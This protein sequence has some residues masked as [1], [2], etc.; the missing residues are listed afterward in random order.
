MMSTSAYAIPLQVPSK[1]RTCKNLRQHSFCDLPS[2][3]LAELER[4][5]KF[6]DY[7]P[8]ERIFREGEPVDELMIVCEGAVTLTFSASGGN[9]MMLGLSECGEMLGLSSHL[10]GHPHE[11]TADAL[12]NTKIACISTADFIRLC[13]RF[14]AFSKNINLE[15]SHKV[16]R[17]YDK[18]RLVGSG[19]SVSQRLAAWLLQMQ[20]EHADD[21]GRI[22]IT[23]THEQMAQLL[24][25]TRESIT[26]ALS[27]FK[28]DGVIVVRGIHY[29]LR[30]TN[31]L[32]ASLRPPEIDIPVE[33][34]LPYMAEL[35]DVCH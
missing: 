23:L 3:V 9:V 8:G 27:K 30:D 26:R 29:Y 15:L 4:V 21:E 35:S 24:G 18:I 6:R 20:A 2:E 33:E 22:R 12:V 34:I 19:L 13:D 10:S 16:N 5:K 7:A 1:C 25:V 28:R 31:F 14:P 32:R 11:T 17:A